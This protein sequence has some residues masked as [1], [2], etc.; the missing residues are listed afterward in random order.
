MDP[1]PLQQKLSGI[2]KRIPA[3]SSAAFVAAFICA[4]AVHLY[5]FTNLIPNGDG[6]DRIF[7]EQEMT[8]SGRW[9]LTFVTRLTGST[10]AP[11]L[12][13]FVSVL[14]LALAAALIVSCLGIR[15]ALYGA[16]TGACMVISI[17]LTYTYAF[18][19]TASAYAIAILMS[20]FSFWLTRR[21]LDDSFPGKRSAQILCLVLSAVILGCSLGIYQAYF[22]LALALWLAC[23]ILDA[24][25]RPLKSGQLRNALIT[26]LMFVAAL[27]FYI[28]MLKIFL[29]VKDLELLSYR[30]MD[31]FASGLS[32]SWL[33][34]RTLHVYKDFCKYLFVPGA[35]VYVTVPMNVINVLL[36]LCGIAVF[37]HEAV[38]AARADRRLS[39]RRANRKARK[40]NAGNTSGFS[41]AA[42]VVSRILMVLAILALPLACD[43]PEL[44]SDSTPNMRFPMVML[45]LFLITMIDR[46]VRRTPDGCAATDR[47]VRRTHDACAATDRTGSGTHADMLSERASAIESAS[48]QERQSVHAAYVAERRSRTTAVTEAVVSGLLCVML[49][50]TAQFANRIYTGLSIAHE[51]TESFL[52]TL[53]ARIESMEGYTADKEVIIIGTPPKSIL[54][55]GVPEFDAISTTQAPADTVIFRNKHIYYYLEKW[56]NVPWAEPSEDTMKEVSDSALFQSMPLY[57]DDGSIV[58]NGDR[59]IVR[60]S[61]KYQPKWDMEIAYENRR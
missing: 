11:G 52:T 48:T 31:Q 57:P 4:Y 14:A 36:M 61:E 1:S 50:L 39:G 46:A 32:V 40:K 45:Y 25:Q 9:F 17:P 43:F 51:A 29:R 44:L 21:A 22:G 38:A 19:F 28:V 13:G 59:V 58:I 37:I 60:L 15:S 49:L 27:V 55:T 41:H 12:I 42:L 47:T 7:D 8:I 6:I 53:T 2:G 30:G 18:M 56:M 33:L 54:R 20:V 24:L 26:L 35:F 3:A 23:I 10:E 16:L 5:V 34:S